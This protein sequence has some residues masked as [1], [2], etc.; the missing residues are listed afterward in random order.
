MFMRP[1]Q[2]IEMQDDGWLKWAE[3]EERTYPLPFVDDDEDRYLN[4]DDDMRAEVD[5]PRTVVELKM[6]SLSSNLREKPSW[7]QKS[8]DS[9]IVAKWREEA[10]GQQEGLPEEDQLTPT[11]VDY[12]LAE[13]AGYAKLSDGATGIEMGCC[14]RVWKS[15]SLISTELRDALLKCVSRLED[16]P[17]DEKD[18]HPNSN[19]QVLDLVHPSLYPLVYGRTHIYEQDGTGKLLA[20]NPERAQMYSSDKYQWLPADFDINASGQATLTSPYINNLDRRKHGRLYKALERLVGAAVPM[21]NRVLSDLRRPLTPP[22]VQTSLVYSSVGHFEYYGMECI[23]GRGGEPRC[24]LEGNYDN[25]EYEARLKTQ[26][27][28]LPQGLTKYDG[29]LD[30]IKQTINLNNSRIQARDRQ[31]R[32]HCPD[33]GRATLSRDRGMSKVVVNVMFISPKR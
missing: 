29:A 17:D 18:W 5:L 6:N 19:K 27:K 10:I 25:D 20:E 3:R 30:A 24:P 22:R 32:Q 31:A 1:L 21:R 7:I 23:W 11:M 14:E 2:R 15:D 33:A 8:Q 16:V 9:S 26:P 12:V 4:R 28:K 13:L